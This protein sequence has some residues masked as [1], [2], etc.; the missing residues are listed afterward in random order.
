MSVPVLSFLRLTTAVASVPM[1]AVGLFCAQPKAVAAQL[2]ET[3]A[4]PAETTML[5]FCQ[6]GRR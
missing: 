3:V 6:I 1:L 5:W 2:R 4:A